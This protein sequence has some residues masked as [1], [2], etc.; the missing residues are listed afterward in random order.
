MSPAYTHLRAYFIHI[1][2]LS[3]FPKISI[4]RTINNVSQRLLYRKHVSSDLADTVR[5]G[6][7]DGS[8]VCD[9]Q[10]GYELTQA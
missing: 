8:S 2:V 6:I 9:E 10:L 4:L 5:S 1:P 7:S 3:R